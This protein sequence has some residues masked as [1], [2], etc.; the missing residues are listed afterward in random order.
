MGKP[1]QVVPTTNR[2]KPKHFDL[3]SPNLNASAKKLAKLNSTATFDPITQHWINDHDTGISV[4][5]LP[6]L[7]HGRVVPDSLS[8][9][10][11]IRLPRSAVPHFAIHRKCHKC[12]R[13]N[14][15]RLKCSVFEQS[16]E[17][18]CRLGSG[19]MRDDPASAID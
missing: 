5:N 4:D 10:Q 13:V 16:P 2:H 6:V 12:G 17:L 7:D 18:G 9:I 19:W 1:I 15:F 3:G 14:Y 11:Q 8:R